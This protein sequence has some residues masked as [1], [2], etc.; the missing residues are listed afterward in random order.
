MINMKKISVLLML[1]AIIMVQSCKSDKKADADAKAATNDTLPINSATKQQ[2]TELPGAETNN[3]AG[4]PA[5]TP[6]DALIFGMKDATIIWIGSKSTG[7]THTGSLSGKS[8]KV[9]YHDGNI[10]SGSIEI[11]MN[12]LKSSD[13]AGKDK[14][15]LESH[16]KSSE[17]FDVAKY[18][19]AKFEIIKISPLDANTERTASMKSIV[20]LT[21]IMTGN[22]TI[23]GVTRAITVPVNIN[24]KAASVQITSSMFTIDRSL[25]GVNYDIGTISG[26]AKEA[27]VDDKISLQLNFMGVKSAK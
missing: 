3:A 11:D 24:I 8:G 5:A 13:L 1:A 25:W 10:V 4:Q 2:L 15:K 26:A 22:L 20:N 16:L 23:K 9:A 21:N 27:I 17:F 6:D 14:A 19:T 7:S 18:P 12:S